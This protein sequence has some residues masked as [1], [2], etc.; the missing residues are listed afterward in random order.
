MKEGEIWYLKKYH[1][2]LSTSEPENTRAKI[3]STG[4]LILG[5]WKDEIKKLVHDWILKKQYED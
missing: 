2:P 3:S 4:R 5:E 1:R